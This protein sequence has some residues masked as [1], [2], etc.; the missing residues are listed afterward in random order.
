MRPSM[1]LPP[2]VQMAMV[3]AQPRKMIKAWAKWMRF[4]VRPRF[5]PDGRGSRSCMFVVGET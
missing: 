4:L 1:P 3:N 2:F 5:P